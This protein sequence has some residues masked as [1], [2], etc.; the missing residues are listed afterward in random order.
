MATKASPE[1]N[2]AKKKSMMGPKE[3]WE[4]GDAKGAGKSAV[5]DVM[6]ATGTTGKKK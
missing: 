4:V 3:N 6:K 2:L 1:F 5:K